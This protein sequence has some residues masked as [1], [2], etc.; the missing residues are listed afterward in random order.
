MNVRLDVNLLCEGCLD[1]GLFEVYKG[2]ELF[3]EHNDVILNND[4]EPDNELLRRMSK[5]FL[6]ASDGR[7]LCRKCFDRQHEVKR[8]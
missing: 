3:V 5:F 4:E 6:V 7:V 1:A 8:V 2:D